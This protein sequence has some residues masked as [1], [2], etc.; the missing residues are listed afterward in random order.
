MARG[1]NDAAGVVIAAAVVAG[2]AWW[3]WSARP[4][5]VSKIFSASGDVIAG[6]PVPG[7]CRVVEIPQFPSGVRRTEVCFTP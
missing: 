3:L 2:V 1:G 5:A 7:T 6:A 4:S